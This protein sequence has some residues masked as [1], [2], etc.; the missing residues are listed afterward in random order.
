M[1]TDEHPIAPFLRDGP[2]APH[3]VSRAAASA[4]SSTASP[5]RST[6]SDSIWTRSAIVS[7]I[8]CTGRV[9]GY[10]KLDSFHT[11]HGRA[12]PF[13]TGLKLGQS[14][15]EGRRSTPATAT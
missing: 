12:I 4:P 8:G 1:Q 10:M 14:R 11:T 2:D 15:A 5:A 6:D 13:A 7:G 3:L 9:A